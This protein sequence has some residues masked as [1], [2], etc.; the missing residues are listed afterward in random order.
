MDTN[1]MLKALAASGNMIVQIIA[2]GII[3]GEST[4]EHERKY[5]GSFMSAVLDG[6]FE[7][8]VRNA[9]NINLNAFYKYMATEGEASVAEFLLVKRRAEA[10][11]II[12][13]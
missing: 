6:N 4:I 8:A 2:K 5:T 3:S 1:E 13:M 11:G 12:L 10:L 9:D 7:E